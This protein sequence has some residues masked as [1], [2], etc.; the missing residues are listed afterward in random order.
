MDFKVRK[1]K[2]TRKKEGFI[3]KI[4]SIFGKK[5]TVFFSIIPVVGICFWGFFAFISAPNDGKPSR[6]IFSPLARDEQGH[7]NI[8]F[9]GVAG[10]Q[11]EGGHLSDS[12]MIASINPSPASVSFLSLPRDLF[13][14]SSVGNHKVNEIFARAR[15]K[16]IAPYVQEGVKSI[17]ELDDK[18]L[19]NA[20]KAGLSVVKEA[21][22]DFTG[23][24]IHYGVVVNFAA[25]EEIINTLGGI[26]VFVRE[27]IEDPFYP[28]G[29]YGYDTFTIRRGL[30]HLDGRT[31]LKYARSR[32][33]SSDYNRAQ[34][35]QD[36]LLG[37]REKAA[38]KELLTDL[39]KLEEFYQVFQKNVDMDLGI[40]E[41]IALA[42]IGVGIDYQTVVSAVLN[43]DSSQKGGFLH[44]PAKDLYGGQFVLLPTDPEETKKFIELLLIYPE[45]LLEKAQ[46]AI[47]NGSEVEG[48]ARSMN[49][50]LRRMGFHIIQVGNYEG[51]EFVPKTFLQNVSG[52]EFSG[53]TDL[54]THLLSIPE[55]DFDS[56]AEP[57]SSSDIVDL[58]IIIGEDIN[59]S[60]NSLS[61]VLP[62]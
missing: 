55:R 18:T 12:I 24:P 31:A 28:D 11:E 37:M 56:V 43:D 54:L 32:K 45:V 44:T 40:T 60:E 25:F 22:S 1:I 46:I 4:T 47:L 16:A 61:T 26:D 3:N 17:N 51:G 50:R 62:E 2:K 30:Q 57:R 9:L 53:T 38:K 59:S 35:Q 20:D 15:S 7:T 10:P 14:E 49:M 5:G 8:V 23:I 41:V 29:N 13:V 58:R 19:K 39:S 27:D 48:V 42:K 34:R 6:S 36:I 33:T 52:N 21:L